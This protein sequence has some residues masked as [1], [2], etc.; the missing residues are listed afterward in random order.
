MANWLLALTRWLRGTR[1]PLARRPLRVEVLEDRA[2]P[3]TIQA[4]YASASFA[5]LIGLDQVRASYPY[6]GDGY[7]VA[8]LDTGI[9]SSNPALAGRVIAGYNFV[10]N[11]SNAQDDNGHGTHV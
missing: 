4:T 9:D 11:S 5:A 6:K 10:N 2:M 8:V 7:S 3:A 1:C